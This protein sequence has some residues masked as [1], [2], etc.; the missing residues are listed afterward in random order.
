[1][2]ISC[3]FHMLFMCHEIVFLSCSP[4]HVKTFVTIQKQAVGCSFLAPCSKKRIA[5]LDLSVLYLIIVTNLPPKK[6]ICLM[7][8]PAFPPSLKG[9]L[10]ANSHQPGII[11][12]KCTK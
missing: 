7:A 6:A 3:E 5:G 4:N 9:S 10:P 11:A 1:M 8:I 2:C 12:H